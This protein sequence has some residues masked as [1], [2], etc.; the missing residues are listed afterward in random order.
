MRLALACLVVAACGNDRVPPLEHS[1]RDVFPARVRLLTDAQIENAIHDLLGRAI[2]VPPIE[3]PGARAHQFI[4]PD[5]ISVDAAQLSR[6][7]AMARDVAAQ[8]GGGDALAFAERAFRRPLEDDERT[9]LTAMTVEGGF[10]LVVEA[11]LQSPQ[12]LYRTEVSAPTLSP[13]ELATELGFFFYDS[14]PDDQLWLAARDGSITD[15]ESLASEVDRLL[16]LPRT[17]TH[18]DGVILDWLGVHRV[19]TTG[20]DAALFPEMTPELR[21]SMLAETRAFV[22]DV[23]WRR[24]GSLRELLTSSRTFIDASL[25]GSIYGVPGIRSDKLVEVTLDPRERAGVLTHASILSVLASARSESIIARGAF[26]SNKLLCEE[27]LGRPPAAAIAAVSSFTSKLTESQF[28]YYRAQNLYC[29]TCHRTMDPPGR[30]L[31]AY[32]GIGRHRKN[33]AAGFPVDDDASVTIA[34]ARIDV[35]DAMQ[36]ARALADSDHVARCVIDQLAHHA[37]GRTLG[38]MDG[39]RD[40]IYD[41]FNASDRSLVEVFRAIATSPAFTRRGAP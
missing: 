34:T 16:D 35:E 28:G 9:S 36:M 39:T 15:P 10:S 37:F 13:Y 1:D 11:V 33:D 18:L 19:L 17:Q 23:M 32:D 3:T 5:V 7:Q 31:H 24:D 41:R 27:P 14:V 2:A 4:Y 6:Y 22:H 40:H 26:V 25:A 21:A 38:T 12:F 20:K 8:V 29:A 30:A